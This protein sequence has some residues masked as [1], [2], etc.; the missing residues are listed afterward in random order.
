MVIALATA[1]AAMKHTKSALKSNGP[2]LILIGSFLML[3]AFQILSPVVSADVL[4]TTSTRFTRMRAATATN[5][6][7]TFT[8]PVGNTGTEDSLR[9]SFPDAYTVA[10]S[11]ITTDTASCGATALP[12]TLSATGSNTNGSKNITIS[13]VT[14]LTA[15]TAYCVDIARATNDPVTNPAAGE[16]ILT[17]ATRDSG[18][19]VIDSTRTAARVI[20]D[21]QIVVSA[22]VPPNF[23]FVIDSNT[24]AF[25]DELLPTL[26]RQTTARTVTINTNATQGWITWARDSNT[27]LTSAAAGYTIASTTPGTA[28]TLTAGTDGYVLGV[29]ATDASGGGTVTVTTAY[30]GTAANNNGSGLDTNF[31]QIASSTGTAN[32]D[33]LTL[34]GKATV[35]SVTPAGTDYTDTWTIIGAG[36]Y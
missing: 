4:R 27:G 11:G 7:V 17:V 30:Q 25:T 14:N 8:V 31:R 12:G 18:S 20:S 1:I 22:S 35:T 9:V 26:V 34:R 29:E 24:T 16:Y 23:N 15:S 21:D 6:R 33:V 36:S 5:I 13:G 28:A 32:G 19:T 2:L 3:F 10:T